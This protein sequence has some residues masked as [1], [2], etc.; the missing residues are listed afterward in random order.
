[1]NHSELIQAIKEIA[2]SLGD[3]ALGAKALEVELEITRILKEKGEADHRWMRMRSVN[4]RI[5]HE[6]GNALVPLDTHGQLF[7]TKMDEPQFRDSLRL[8]LSQNVKRILQLT[9]FLRLSRGL[10]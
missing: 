2:Q 6:V 5:A 8:A 1:M 3:S 10:L 9:R 4:D 7:P